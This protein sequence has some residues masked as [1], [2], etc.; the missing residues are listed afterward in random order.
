M[1]HFGFKIVK[2]EDFKVKSLVELGPRFIEHTD[3]NSEYP[4][5]YIVVDIDQHF[6]TAYS[7]SIGKKYRSVEQFLI[8]PG[9]R[10]TSF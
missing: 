10:K 4:V 8:R 5:R 9:S 3:Y 6:L 7:K 2:W 1:S